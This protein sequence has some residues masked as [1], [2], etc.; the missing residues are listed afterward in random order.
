MSSILEGRLNPSK[1]PDRSVGLEKECVSLR[2]QPQESDAG[3]RRGGSGLKQTPP[4]PARVDGE[5]TIC[6][7]GRVWQEKLAMACHHRN[8]WKFSDIRT[9]SKLQWFSF[10]FISPDHEDSP[11]IRA[12]TL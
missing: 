1:G 6:W 4:E 7:G 8:S 9:K 2:R 3:M 5:Y 12:A 10:F 11:S